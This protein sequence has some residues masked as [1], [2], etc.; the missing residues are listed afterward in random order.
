[1]RELPSARRSRRRCRS[2]PIR[3][4][5]PWAGS[6]REK[7]MS[8]AMPPWHADRQ[9][10]KFRNDQQPRRESR[11]RHDRQ[12]GER[13][14]ARG[15]PAALPRA[16]EV[17]GG[18]ADRHAR[19]RVR[20]AGDVPGPGDAA[21]STTSTSRCRPT[22]PKIAGCRPAKC[23][24]AI[25][26]TCTTSSSRE[27]TGADAASDRRDRQADPRRS[28]PRAPPPA[29]GA[30]AAARVRQRAQARRRPREPAITCS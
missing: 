21:R 15:R 18:L 13:G 4:V 27:R 10:G 16:A 1:M 12:L 20:D 17:P 6:I 5:R 23:A 11:D 9:H 30:R 7:V 29:A 25:A 24:R 28:A 14:R 22:S 19:R 26:S 3:D 2:S 8:R